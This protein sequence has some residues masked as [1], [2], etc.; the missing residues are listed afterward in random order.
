MK[1]KRILVVEDDY[2]QAQW[3]LGDLKRKYKTAPEL[4]MTEHQF[5][6]RLDKIE[7]EPPWDVA[8]IDIMLPWTEPHPEQEP[9]P[10]DIKKDGKY[11]AGF[12]CQTLL[13]EKQET[14]DLP[15]ILYSM[16]DEKALHTELG[17]LPDHI[18]FLPKRSKTDK[19]IDMID[20]LT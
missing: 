6:K 4:I 12:R 3:L 14:K 15:V 7:K 19:L 20:S 1:E 17:D 13:A 16:L 18:V 5:R 9:M 10:E 11:R 2:Q 8:I